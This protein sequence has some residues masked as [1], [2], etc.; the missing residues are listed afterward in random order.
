MPRLRPQRLLLLTTIAVAIFATGLG[1]W[2]LVHHDWH[3][4]TVLVDGTRREYLWYA[5]QTKS[6]EPRP[7]VLAYHGFSGT[8]ERME[9]RSLLH[10]LVDSGDFYLAYI[11]GDPTW[12][13]FTPIELDESP[14]VA[15]VDALLA[16][17]LA[18]YPID[19]KKVYAVGVSKG[20][21]FV[22][23]LG[24]RRSQQIAAIVAQGA[25]ILEEQQ[26]E[27]PLAMMFI[28]GTKDGE[29]TPET[30]V[31][32]PQTY[33][34]RGHLVEVIRPK[35]GPHCWDRSYNQQILE[36]LFG[37]TTADAEAA[38]EGT[39]QAAPDDEPAT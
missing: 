3:R 35:D 11:E 27:R 32:V 10:E 28:V 19:P 6:T 23:H 8:A 21:D 36:F 7:L 33:R 14:D 20:G 22:V 12:H 9:R 17:V 38:P 15:M 25:C 2:W 31:A 5:P 29:V 37:H 30:I 39:E 24:L 18:K 1:V 26:A 16:D 13:C 34:D 4:R